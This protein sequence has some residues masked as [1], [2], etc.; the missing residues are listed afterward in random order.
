VTA[1]PHESPGGSVRRLSV[2]ALTRVEGE[3]ALRVRVADGR[4]EIAEFSIYEP[5][6][7]FEKLVCGREISEVP[8]IVARICGICPVA[9]QLTACHALE[10][11]LGVG[12]TPPIRMLRRLL[13]CGEWIQS[14][15]LHVHLL[16]APDFFGCE[17]GFT[18]A[19]QRPKLVEA[20]MRLK[21]IGSRLIAGLGGRAVHPI[22][23]TVG[24]FHRSPSAAA[25]RELLPDLE[26]GLR[27]CLDLVNEVSRFEF[28]VFARGYHCVAV[29]HP[30]EYPLN[31]GRIVSSSG[32]DIDAGEFLKHISERQVP[33]STALQSVFLPDE[34]TYLVGP[35]ARL[36]LCHD[37][38]PPAARAAAEGCGHPLPLTNPFMS[39]VARCVELAA[40]FEEAAAIVRSLPAAL[41]AC[42]VAWTPRAGVG[43]HATEA[44][45]GL[46][47]HRYEIGADG[48]VKT[49]AI[50]PP[51]SQNQAQIEADLRDLL[52][53][54]LGADDATLTL[55]CERLIRSYDPCISCATHFLRLVVDRL[56][57]TNP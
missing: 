39:I 10:Q 32:L 55:A 40:A 17:S 3:G 53:P 19:E 33:W 14:H 42:R 22:N 21:S 43:C 16:H 57:D 49:A 23:V 46:L 52:P 36:N 5:P 27:H 1:A 35:L 13:G 50:M 9:Y 2:K 8:D 18:L 25:V 51:T 45:R 56:G 37:R 6:R 28:P 29:A 11:A 44:P 15:A 34:Q 47:W 7:F 41:G 26:W 12:I 54:L 30:S 20:G 31:E 4:I 38:L 48:L 24:G